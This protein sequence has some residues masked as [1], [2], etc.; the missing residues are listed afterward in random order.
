MSGV[1]L[2]LP[3]TTRMTVVQLKNGD[4]FLHS[5]TSVARPKP[6]QSVDP[7]SVSE[8]R[9]FSTRCNRGTH[10]LK[11]PVVGPKSRRSIVADE[12]IRDRL[13]F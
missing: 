10:I 11:G 12:R 13:D 3:F 7:D 4:L 8:I 2:P 1:R 5:P 6:P 9:P